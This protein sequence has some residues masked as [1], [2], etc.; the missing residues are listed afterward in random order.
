ML[1]GPELGA[2]IEAA[3]IKKGVTKVAMAEYFGVQP[4]SIQDW[5]KR[6]T[7]DKAKLPA[8]WQ[9]FSDVANASHWG[10]DD[11]EPIQHPSEGAKPRGR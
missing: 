10:L 6:G 4:P 1:N 11:W 5:V 2:A 9:Y 3:R 8:L 7:I